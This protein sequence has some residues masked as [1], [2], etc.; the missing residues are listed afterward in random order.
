LPHSAPHPDVV[1]LVAPNGLGHFRRSIGI[2]SRLLERDPGIQI[3]V[4]CAEWQ[5]GATRDWPRSLGFFEDRRVS[6]T[7]GIMDPGVTWAADPGAYSASLLN[8]WLERCESLPQ[9]AR[10]S[11]VISDNL[12]TVLALRPDAVLLGSFLW[13]D[14]L[15]TAHPSVPAVQEFA[16]READ[17]MA[18]HQP[19]MLCVEDVVMPAV[20]RQ[21]KAV[22][23]GWMCEHDPL[24][25][26]PGGGLP[27]VGILGG[28]TGSADSLL[29]RIT[30]W[31]AETGR[32]RLAVAGGRERGP[33]MGTD[34]RHTPEEYADLD[35][36]VCRPGVGTVTDCIAQGVPM[37]TLH[38]G[39]V[40]PELAH[41]G[42]RL[43]ELGLALDLGP[44]PEGAAVVAAVQAAAESARRFRTTIL[45]RRRD[46][47][48]G[49]VDF[50]SARLAHASR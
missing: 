31:L 22:P 8:G 21:A 36:A 24:D 11:V 49:A 40:N 26:R 16:A 39:P 28:A 30:G 32:Y 46:G 44:E 20:L 41:N 10:A 3:H 1:A 29:R 38:E 6:R 25:R 18:R 37:V 48:R 15:K 33:A 5:V 19:P 13:G 23:L 34:F 47:L 14:V 7:G 42:A 27:K 45:A 2:L 35:V 50:L 9:L 12:G 43:A 17:L 4:A